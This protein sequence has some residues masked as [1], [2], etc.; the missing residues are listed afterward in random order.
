MTM[1]NRIKQFL[2]LVRN[3]GKPNPA[4]WGSPM[5]AALSEGYIKVGWSGRLELT[6]AGRMQISNGD[7][8]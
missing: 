1:D 2:E 6:D 4:A 3:G 5:R 8:Q 7:G